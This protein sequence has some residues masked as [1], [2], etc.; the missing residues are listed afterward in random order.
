MAE[1]ITDE[2]LDNWLASSPWPD[3]ATPPWSRETCRRYL[4]DER[5]AEERL[6]ARR[7]AEA[8]RQAKVVEQAELPALRAQV[9]H[10]RGENAALGRRVKA[11][12]FLVGFKDKPCSGVIGDAVGLAM[13]T[14]R[15]EL[16]EEFDKKFEPR[17]EA[18]EQRPTGL[19][20][21]GT[22]SPGI[23]YPGS[24]VVIENGTA[25]VALEPTCPGEKPGAGGQW[26]LML[27]SDEVVLRK[28]IR[29][30]MRKPRA[31]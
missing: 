10:L 21:K 29:D 18:L 7:A 14:L 9:A 15:K 2:F 16:R 1:P 5:N 13:A 20:W 26:R 27:K 3:R 11:L 25:W 24:A 30:E 31:A 19:Q 12:E 22:W 23:A 8:A 17:I 4:Q 28:L 6:Q